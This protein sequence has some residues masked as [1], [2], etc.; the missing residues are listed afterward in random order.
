MEPGTLAKQVHG[1][2]FSRTDR[3]RVIQELKNT[4]RQ[5]TG[6]ELYT[7]FELITGNQILD[8]G[9]VLKFKK[10]G[11]RTGEIRYEP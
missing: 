4:H 8:F 10:T 1:M 7:D 6:E 5:E 11:N 9:F 3:P 2:I